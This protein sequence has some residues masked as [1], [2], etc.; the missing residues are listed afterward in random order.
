ML[1]QACA[2]V[3]WCANTWP[4]SLLPPPVSRALGIPCRVVT[5][6]GSAH[7]ADANLVI[8]NLYDEDGERISEGDS[9]W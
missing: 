3:S 5:N 7:D 4:S 1:S 8:E 9:I 2:L 6:F